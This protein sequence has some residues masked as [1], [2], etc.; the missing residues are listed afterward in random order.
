V[1]SESDWGHLAPA[2]LGLVDVSWLPIRAAR[3]RLPSL[4]PRDQADMAG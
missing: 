2:L 3:G 1:F 4:R